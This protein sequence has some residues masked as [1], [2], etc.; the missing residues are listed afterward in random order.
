MQDGLC[1]DN[2]SNCTDDTWPEHLKLT[3][4]TYQEL[5]NFDYDREIDMAARPAAWW[6]EWLGRQGY[7]RQPYEYLAS[8]LSRQGYKDKAEDILYAGKNRELENTP[9]P[10]SIKLWL[11][12][13]LIGYGYRIIGMRWCGLPDS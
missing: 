13:V 6:I 9:F 5:E 11:E 8:I 1:R 4:F 12:R 3:G 2:G 10:A 7:S